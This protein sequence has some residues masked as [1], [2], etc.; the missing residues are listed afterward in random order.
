MSGNSIG[1]QWEEVPQKLCWRI[2]Y[3]T[4]TLNKILNYENQKAID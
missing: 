3:E 1:V 2:V 4:K